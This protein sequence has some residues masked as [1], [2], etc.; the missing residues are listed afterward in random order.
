VEFHI[1][2]LAMLDGRYFLSVA[3]H[4]RDHQTDYHWIDKFMYFDVESPGR[5]A[6]YLSMDCEIRWSEG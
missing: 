4:T 6:G 1:P 5:D 3:A 2:H